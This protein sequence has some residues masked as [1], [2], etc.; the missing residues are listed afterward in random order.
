MNSI[1]TIWINAAFEIKIVLRSWFFRIFSGLSLVILFFLDLVMFSDVAGVPKIF[2]GIASYFP[3]A[4]INLI[5]ML[6]QIQMTLMN[7]FIR[8]DAQQGR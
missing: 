3:Y 1:K 5:N 8:V 2:N 7:N 4:N 6:I